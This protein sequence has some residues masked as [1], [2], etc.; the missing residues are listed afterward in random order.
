MDVTSKAYAPSWTFTVVSWMLFCTPRSYLTRLEGA[1]L[2]DT[3]NTQMWR[4]FMGEVQEDW[5]DSITP[6]GVSLSPLELYSM[7]APLQTAVIL[8][9][10]VGFLAIQSVDGS[11]FAESTRSVGQVISYISTLLSIGNIIACTILVRQHRSAS[12]FRDNEMVSTCESLYNVPH[13]VCGCA[14][15]YSVGL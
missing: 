13:W 5:M 10:N 12:A 4:N 7:C 15:A 8:S 2:D 11:G 14:H 9:A 6:V 1:W 3:V